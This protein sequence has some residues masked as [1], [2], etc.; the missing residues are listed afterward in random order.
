M[1]ILTQYYSLGQVLKHENLGSYLS[2]KVPKLKEL[3]G[4]TTNGNL[5][6]SSFRVLANVMQTLER[7]DCT[8]YW[9]WIN[10]PD[11]TLRYMGQTDNNKLA[12]CCAIL[13]HRLLL[14]LCII[15]RM[16]FPLVFLDLVPFVE[17][18]WSNLLQKYLYRIEF[19]SNHGEW[20]DSVKPDLDP[21]LV[22][23][24]NEKLETSDIIIENFKSVRNETRMAINSL[25]KVMFME[26]FYLT[27]LHLA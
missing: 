26:V 11:V 1:S 18:L 5:N 27:F 15:G 12:F 8:L 7:C 14:I 25:L 22:E 13:K 17:I 6:S 3:V 24:L 23:Q 16:F 9:C 10:L 20:I 21:A 4:K 2:S 19:K